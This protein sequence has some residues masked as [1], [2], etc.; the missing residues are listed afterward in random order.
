[1]FVVYKSLSVS[2]TLYSIYLLAGWTKLKSRFRAILLAE[3]TSTFT[4]LN[5]NFFY[6]N[7]VRE[8]PHLAYYYTSF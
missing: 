4:R 5:A 3:E 6:Y 7:Y 8:L 1:M 2:V